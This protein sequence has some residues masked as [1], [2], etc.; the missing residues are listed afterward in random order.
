MSTSTLALIPLLPLLAAA[1]TSGMQ[2]GRTAAVLAIGALLGSCLTALFAFRQSWNMAAKEYLAFDIPWLTVGETTVNFG[3]VLNP[4]TG[5]M[6]AMVTFVGLLIF[7]YSACYR[8]FAA[9]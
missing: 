1:I 8:I 4:L 2:R 6:T 5:V 7:V 9:L 3:F